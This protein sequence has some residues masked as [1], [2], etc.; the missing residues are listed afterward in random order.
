MCASFRAGTNSDYAFAGVHSCYCGAISSCVDQFLP[1]GE[2]TNSLC[3]HYLAHHRDEV[4][5]TDID[6][7]MA[8]GDGESGPTEAELQ[9]PE[10]MLAGIGVR[11]EK[12]LGTK[13]IE[14]WQSV[15]LDVSVL[16][17]CL[18]GGCLPRPQ[19]FTPMR[20]DAEDLFTV[21]CAIPLEAIQYIDDAIV[22]S[23]G[24]RAAWGGEAFRLPGLNRYLWI[25]LLAELLQQPQ[26]C[27]PDAKYLRFVKGQLEAYLGA[28]RQTMN[29]SNP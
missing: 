19:I 14:F 24:S 10:T 13:R 6:Y 7:A 26:N 25:E 17:S 9:G 2:V 28:H 8:L 11:V 5:V 3:I 15:G 20:S 22:K 21:L 29:R 12:K 23:Y 16:T 18:Q 1:A 27:F 4:P